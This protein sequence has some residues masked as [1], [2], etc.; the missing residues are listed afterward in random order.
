MNNN[1]TTPGEYQTGDVVEYGDYACLGYA[2]A[3]NENGYTAHMDDGEELPTC[4]VCGISTWWV[5]Y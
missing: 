2:C 5:K 4:P 3:E 1:N